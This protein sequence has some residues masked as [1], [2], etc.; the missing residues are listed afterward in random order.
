MKYLKKYKL[1][2]STPDEEWSTVEERE[3]TI[4]H[5]SLEF[6][7]V[8][9]I[10][11]IS[12]VREDVELEPDRYNGKTKT[13]LFLEVYLSRNWYSP[14]RE[15]PGVVN[16]EGGYPGNLIFWYEI[17][18]II[19]RIAKWYYE[20]ESIYDPISK[21]AVYRDEKEKSPLRFFGS[22]IEMLIGCSKEEDFEK[23]GDFI[24]FTNFRIMIKISEQV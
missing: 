22:G 17:K 14:N 9:L 11:S 16:P 23:L 21:D 1:F 10:C 7:D 13:E 3:N 4:R 2:E 12:K 8:G 20:V 15:I 6:E 19:I 5:I 24:S 18:N